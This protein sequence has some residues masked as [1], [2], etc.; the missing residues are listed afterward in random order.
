L[1]QRSRYGPGAP[2]GWVVGGNQ[3]PHRT[4]PERDLVRG[5]N[6]PNPCNTGCDSPRSG[7][8]CQRCALGVRQTASDKVGGGDH[9]SKTMG[10]CGRCTQFVGRRIRDRG[11]TQQR[12][13]VAAEL[14]GQSARRSAAYARQVARSRPARRTAGRSTSLPSHQSS[15]LVRRPPEPTQP[16]GNK[17]KGNRQGQL[18]DRW[19][20]PTGERRQAGEDAQI[21]AFVASS[22]RLV[23]AKTVPVISWHTDPTS[24]Y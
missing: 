17:P 6:R 8:T 21:P 13:G 16:G 10:T 24:T 1:G 18:A 20:L 19:P 2:V 5:E 7:I 11:G 14:W 15:R 12:V 3:G 9:A 22:N 4:L 23:V